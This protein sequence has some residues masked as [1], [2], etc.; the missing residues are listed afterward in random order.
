[1]SART[2]TEWQAYCAIEPFGPQAD[3]W[4]AGLIASILANVNRAKKSDKLFQP[5]DFM[6]NGLHPEPVKRDDA[7]TAELL[8]EQFRNYNEILKHHGQPPRP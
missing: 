3:F 5:E 2:F 4:R 6:P 8:S 7:V 1:M